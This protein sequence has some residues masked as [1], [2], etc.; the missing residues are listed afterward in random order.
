MTEIKTETRLPPNAVEAEQALLG[1]LLIDNVA[2]PR[3]MG[4]IIPESFYKPAHGKIYKSML[5]LFEKNETI[6]TITVIDQIKKNGD[7]ESVGGPYYISGLSIEIPSSE[8]VEYYAKIV[9]DK[10]T[11]R[12]VI[13]TSIDLSSMAYEGN[14]EVHEILD[15]AEQKLFSLSQNMERGKCSHRSRN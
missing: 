14:Y 3:I 2:L 4:I 15:K 1:C 10:Y 9:A 13:T 6:D 5:D 7:L 11:L 12:T 8:N